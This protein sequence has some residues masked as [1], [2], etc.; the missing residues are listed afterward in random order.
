MNV[1]LYVQSDYFLFREN[2]KSVKCPYMGC[3]CKDF[4]KTDLVKD[5]EVLG[6]LNKVREEQ[7]KA[8]NEKKEEELRAREERKRK[9]EQGHESDKSADSIVDEVIE[10]IRDKNGKEIPVSN[11]PNLSET[12]SDTSSSTS[13]NSSSSEAPTSKSSADN[14]PRPEELGIHSQPIDSESGK[15]NVNTSKSIKRSNKRRRMVSESDDSVERPISKVGSKRNRKRPQKLND[16]LSCSELDEAD[17]D[18]DLPERQIRKNSNKT[19]KKIK[20]VGK[21]VTETWCIQKEATRNP[22]KRR[23]KEKWSNILPVEDCDSDEDVPL[24]RKGK[25]SKNKPPKNASKDSLRPKRAQKISY[26][27]SD[28]DF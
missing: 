16:S 10:M 3:N 24:S 20:I 19:A 1:F 17:S 9:K 22:K 2:S 8:E 5:K 26:A 21:K 18:N 7:E 4:K 12:S 14:E 27:E 23:A 28:D 6:H 13:D 11:E 15:R 25:S